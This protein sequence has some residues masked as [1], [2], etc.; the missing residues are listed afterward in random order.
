M[1]PYPRLCGF[2]LITISAILNITSLIPIDEPISTMLFML[3]FFYFLLFTYYTFIFLKL[4]HYSDLEK[5]HIS[6]EYYDMISD[7]QNNN[8]RLVLILLYYCI[9]VGSYSF[10]TYLSK[11]YSTLTPYQQS[12]FAYN[13]TMASFSIMYIYEHRNMNKYLNLENVVIYRTENENIELLQN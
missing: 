1:I 11:K 2:L 4:S 8:I 3:S 5:R 7:K 6:Q 13:Y 9:L 10:P 12:I